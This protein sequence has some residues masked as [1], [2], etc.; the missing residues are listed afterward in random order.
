M[1]GKTWRCECQHGHLGKLP[2]RKNIIVKAWVGL[3]E[4][5]MRTREREKWERGR[6]YS[7]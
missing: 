2:G 7:R 4:K 5:E 1:G 3:R 6:L